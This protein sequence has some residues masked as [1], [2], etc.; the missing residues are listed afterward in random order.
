MQKTLRTAAVVAGLV[1][2]ALT[3]AA[4]VDAAAGKQ[5]STVYEFEDMDEVGH[6]T[7]HRNASGVTM[8]IKTGVSGELFDFDTPLGVDWKVGDATT[9]W[10]VVFNDPGACEDGCGEDEVL[11]AIFGNN[12][13]KVGVHYGAGH[14]AGSSRFNASARL[15]EGDMSGVLFGMGLMDAMAAEVHLV[16]R[17]HGPA[18][19]LSGPE[20]AAALHTVDGGCYPDFGPNICGDSQFAV[21]L[22][23]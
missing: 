16:V 8:N 14:V 12:F 7:L 3:S 1:G 19:T 6:A 23:D 9:V 13:A 15:N 10:F 4:P 17:S 5:H 21:F 11:A 2:L 20:L 18:S 22:A